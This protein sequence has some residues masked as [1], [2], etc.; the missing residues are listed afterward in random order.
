M[1]RQREA[2]RVHLGKIECAIRVLEVEAEMRVEQATCF[3][4]LAAYV[5]AIEYK[6][7]LEALSAEA[8]ERAIAIRARIRLIRNYPQN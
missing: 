7:K 4:Q 1:R 8:L 3:A 5:N 2:V 6:L